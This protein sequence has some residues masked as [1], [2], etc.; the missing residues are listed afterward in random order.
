MM[1]IESIIRHGHR[2]GMYSSCLLA[3]FEFERITRRVSTAP[4][5]HLQLRLSGAFY[6]YH[7]G[8]LTSYGLF[9]SGPVWSNG[10]FPNFASVPD[11]FILSEDEL[12]SGRI[13]CSASYGLCL[14]GP[15]SSNSICG[16]FPEFVALLQYLIHL[17]CPNTTAASVEK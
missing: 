1:S 3:H 17:F 7:Q 4:S 16:V 2:H 15:V 14:S 13:K 8:A 9:S 6:Y 10:V 11:P 5:Y 12:S